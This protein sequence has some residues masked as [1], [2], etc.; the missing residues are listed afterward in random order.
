MSNGSSKKT[1]ENIFFCTIFRIESI[2]P[3]IKRPAA[4][5]I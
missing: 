4:C 1:N 3:G 2:I 5:T